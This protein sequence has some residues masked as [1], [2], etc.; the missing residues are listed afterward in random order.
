[1]SASILTEDLPE[2]EAP[3]WA[4]LDP[5][6]RLELQA[7]L[8]QVV[9]PGGAVL[10][11]EGDTADALYMLVS[12]ALGV[13]IQ[14]SHGEQ[15]RVARISPPETIG[16]MAL[17]SNTPRSASVT[18]LRDSVLLKLTRE[19]F[20]SLVERCPSVMVYLSRLLA[21]RL[22]ATT[23]SSPVTFKPTTYAIVP[24]TQ[25]VALADF[26]QAF[27]EEMRRSHGTRVDLLDAMPSEEDENWL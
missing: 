13:S 17:I 24:V 20:E 27:L 8:Q 14:G 2:F 6:T 12:G 16:E 25:G 4:G 18:A 19:A 1:M 15:R 11:Q 7:E 10:F 3:L 5:M 22:R 23:R 21:D 9:L 26:A